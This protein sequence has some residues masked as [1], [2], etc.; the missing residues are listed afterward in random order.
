MGRSVSARFSLFRLTLVRA[1]DGWCGP[2]RGR[3]PCGVPT[4]SFTGSVAHCQRNVH[5]PT[6]TGITAVSVNRPVDESIGCVFFLYT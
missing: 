2:Y 6:Q 1:T 5:L 4:L 3:W